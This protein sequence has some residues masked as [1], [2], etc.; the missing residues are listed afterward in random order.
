ME[1]ET[2]ELIRK[3]KE[4][5]ISS[6][7]KLVEL[8]SSRVS[9]IIYQLLGGFH[10]ETD[11]LAQMVFIKVYHHLN[12][13]RAEAKF[14]TW[15]YRITVNTVWDYLRKQKHRKTVSLEALEQKG[16]C[17]LTSKPSSVTKDVQQEELKELLGRLIQEL[18]LKYRTVLIL[19]ELENLSYKEISKVVNC[20]IGTVESRL[21]RARIALKDKI[22][23]S[24]WGRELI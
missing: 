2:K 18:P 15:L 21:F 6:F 14:S 7:E 3:F 17:I 5:N 24:P 1:E 16:P 4:G 8:Y 13:F 10:N 12:N 23:K 9:N 22:Q 11:D 19:K 20:S